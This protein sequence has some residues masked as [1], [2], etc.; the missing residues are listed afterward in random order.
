VAGTI[1]VVAVAVAVLI[2]AAERQLRRDLQT[3]LARGLEREARLARQALP[4]D[5][6]AWG[7]TVRRLAAETGSRIT[8]IDTSGRLTADSDLSPDSLRRHGDH[9]SRPEV[10]AAL[11]GMVG[12]DVRRSATV[13]H[14]LLYVA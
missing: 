11:G 7:A 12:S 9:R 6:S 8:L 10:L 13:G 5:S 4:A 1:L 3:D 2:V 14:P